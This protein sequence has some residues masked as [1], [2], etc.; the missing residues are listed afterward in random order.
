MCRL[1]IEISMPARINAVDI[2]KSELM[3]Y[4]N[5]QLSVKNEFPLRVG[6]TDLKKVI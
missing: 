5:P 1:M 3:F 4:I 6:H 2:R